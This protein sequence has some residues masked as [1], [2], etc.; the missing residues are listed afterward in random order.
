MKCPK[1]NK[2]CPDNETRCAC[3]YNFKT[4]TMDEKPTPKTAVKNFSP[5]VA[6]V[7]SLVIPGLG[8]IYRQKVGIGLLWLLGVVIGYMV[9]VVPGILAHVWC[10]YDAATGSA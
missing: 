6:A 1:C 7:L 2:V 9:L 8:Q 4:K 3:W 10:I 5:G